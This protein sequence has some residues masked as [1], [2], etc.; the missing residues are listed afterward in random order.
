MILRC[1]LWFLAIFAVYN[2][3]TLGMERW[4]AA[5][6]NSFFWSDPAFYKPGIEMR[7]QK[8]LYGDIDGRDVI[9]GSSL[10]E[11]LPADL[12]GPSFEKMNFIGGCPLT[13]LQIIQRAGRHPRRIFIESNYALARYKD[14]KTLANVFDPCLYRL[15]RIFPSLRSLNRPSNVFLLALLPLLKAEPQADAQT[16]RLDLMNLPVKE[17]DYPMDEAHIRAA[18]DL[19]LP[20]FGYFGKDEGAVK[21][22]VDPFCKLVGELEKRG[23]VVC[24]YEMPMHAEVNACKGYRLLQERLHEKYPSSRYLWVHPDP[25]FNYHTLDGF[26][27]ADMSARAYA[28]HL[29]RQVEQAFPR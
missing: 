29:V 12:L 8:G 27:L 11:I 25:N 23:I 7:A 10:T 21:R 19:W 3:A 5:R 16:R 6:S 14:D 22:V 18:L 9:V 24:F 28:Q 20:E 13:G 26:H 17:D 4:L 15:R 1:A 2:L